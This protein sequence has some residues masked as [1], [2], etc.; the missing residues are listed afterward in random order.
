MKSR[1]SDHKWISIIIFFLIAETLWLLAE[2]QIIHIPYFSN[3]AVII[4]ML[5]AGHVTK[6]TSEL[7]RRG[8]NSLVW[9]TAKENDILYYND[10]IL[11]LALSSAKLYLKD[12]TELQLSENTLVMLEEPTVGS[13]SEI[14]LRFSKGDLKARNPTAKAN[15]QGEDWVVNLEKGSEVSLRKNKE[16]YEFEVIAGKASLQTTTGQTESLNNSSI[17]KLGTNHQ[18]EKIEKNQDLQWLDK[19]PVRVYVFEESTRVS[20][21]W[22]GKAQGLVISK[23]GEEE[24]KQVV[25]PEQKVAT[26]DLKLGN[27]K[28][29]LVDDKGLS[30]SRTV[31]VWR[32]P[33][34]LLKKP[35]P[36]D[37]LET[38]KAHEF[39]WTSEKG[40][41]EYRI[42]LG[43]QTKI[44]TDNFKSIQF[45][46][47]LDLDWK[48][49]G[50]DDEGYLI[51][52]FYDSKIYF[53]KN[54][55]QAP[56][57][58]APSL[59][60]PEKQKSSLNRFKW[61]QLLISV[62]NATVSHHEMVFEWETVEGADHYTIEI[63]SE[64]DFRRPDVIE[65]VKTNRYVWKKY[66]SKKKYYWRVAAGSTKGRMGFF[67]EPIELKP[68]VIVESE[69]IA[70][71]EELAAKKSIAR[72]KQIAPVV[73]AIQLPA[74]EAA[75]EVVTEASSGWVLAW[76]PAY[77]LTELSGEQKAKIQLQGLVPLGLHLELKKNDYQLQLWTNSEIWKPSPSSDYP[78]QENLSISEGWLF[79]SHKNVGITLHQSFI[80]IRKT[81]ESIATQAQ[82]IIGL[83]YFIKNYG[84]SVGTTG[85]IHELSLDFKHKKYLS[86]LDSTIK[87]FYGV[88]GGALYQIHKSG[89]GVQGNLIFLIGAES[90]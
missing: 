25:L 68:I 63:S 22:L 27:Y 44:S 79:L 88:A 71:S 38:G 90:F 7:K 17:L 83:R 70:E 28:V 69:N 31:E 34:I 2:M 8:P 73:E 45:D 30:E 29:R 46:E 60:V 42:R 20:L 19:K 4:G 36:R 9:E 49:E 35:L 66:D 86:D 55:L 64:P 23:V 56:K 51:P 48:V 76:A 61:W 33:R 57:L 16:S 12:Q 67:S 80:P 52:S 15:I 74:E 72:E 58:K 21:D 5:E 62:A 13:N 41:R 47:E 81:D 82:I 50:L 84:V 85:G 59:H 37:R 87:Y 40:A 3:R 14:R 6:V 43:D 1:F 89:G 39:V 53:R 78:L 18:V 11:T 54:P 75:E 32:A 24:T 65:N 26:M 10:S 77:K